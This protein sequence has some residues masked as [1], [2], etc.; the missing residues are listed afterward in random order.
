MLLSKK[1]TA[2][3]SRSWDLA[4]YTFALQVT[5]VCEF[6]EDD[7]HPTRTSLRVPK[8]C[9]QSIFSFK[10]CNALG[11][12]W[13]EG[14]YLAV[15]VCIIICDSWKW[16]MIVLVGNF[17]GSW[18]DRNHQCWSHRQCE[19]HSV[20]ISMSHIVGGMCLDL[21][22][23]ESL[24]SLMALGLCYLAEVFSVESGFYV[25]S[26][27]CSELGNVLPAGGV[28]VA[29]WSWPWH[30]L[31]SASYDL[32]VLIVLSAVGTRGVFWRPMLG[33]LTTWQVHFSWWSQCQPL[34]AHWCYGSA[35]PIELQ[36]LRRQ[37]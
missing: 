30:Y 36:D 20:W 31:H 12:S 34:L 32:R 33:I 2:N 19:P 28:D 3:I 24:V 15:D 5:S 1:S 9:L 37:L 8:T 16:S 13:L 21:L 14:R 17:S 35:F 6:R 22:G 23:G 25:F 7:P 29:H 26:P 11:W 4:N 10:S 27:C 18:D